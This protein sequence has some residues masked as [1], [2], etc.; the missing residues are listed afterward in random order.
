[1]DLWTRTF[2][3]VGREYSEIAQDHLY[4]DAAS[5]QMVKSPEAFDVVV[6]SNMFGDILTD[7]GGMIT[8]GLGIAASG[9][10]HPGR[11]S[12]FE[13]VHGSAPKYAGRNVASPMA[14]ILS[15]S[16][17]LDFLG[18]KTAAQRVES[19]L[20]NL[21]SSRRIPSL[22]TDS[23]LSTTQQGDLVVEAMESKAAT[24]AGA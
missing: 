8:G 5:M 10:I 20:A 19:A 12:M 23:G 18:E 16:M 2:E 21:L 9:N 7:L 3:E 1:M 4:V 22:G 13:P 11:T 24:V 14:T 15:V 17:M 6:T